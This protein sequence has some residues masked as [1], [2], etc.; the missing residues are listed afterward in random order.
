MEENWIK[1][2]AKYRFG[3]Q[4]L[5]LSILSSLI[6]MVLGYP[7]APEPVDSAPSSAVATVTAETVRSAATETGPARPTPDVVSRVPDFRSYT[8]VAAKKNDFFAFLLPHVAA[9]NR[10][11]MERRERLT[12]LQRRLDDGI[13]ATDQD[14]RFAQ[15]M[16]R[17]YRVG[18][19]EEINPQALGR[20]LDRVDVI[21]ASLAL[22]QAAN[23][24]GWGTSRFAR[25]ANNF[26]GVWCF[27]PGCGL[28]PERRAASMTHEVKRYDNVADSVSAYIH[29]LNTHPAYRELRAIRADRRRVDHPI[30]GV[31]L[32]EGLERYSERGEE[33][34]R[35]IQRL[36]RTNNL[37]QV[38]SV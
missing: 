7:P 33:Y 20:L 14:I 3:L 21:P 10:A 28:K 24:T 35:D 2:A 32:A 5:K 6:V 25:R 38:A 37:H 1:Y 9:A 19:P 22:A 13:P 11:I 15:E 36:I 8:D 29:T 31:D 34:V 4:F 18:S 30:R 23:E 17:L 27:N 26:F 16:F 12:R